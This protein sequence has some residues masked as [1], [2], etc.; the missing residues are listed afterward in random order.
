MW[1]S[2]W[3]RMNP[4]PS[5]LRLWRLANNSLDRITAMMRRLSRTMKMKKG[6]SAGCRSRG[7]DR[8]LVP[9]DADDMTSS[10]LSGETLQQEGL[11]QDHPLDLGR[12]DALVRGVDPRARQVFGSPQDE[13][14]VRG[15]L[16]QGL[17]QRDRAAA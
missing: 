17:Q 4:S 8:R 12:V 15:R 3:P 11:R 10:S 7:R 16:L 5:R 13:L 1:P 9:T 14:C 2:S 6:T